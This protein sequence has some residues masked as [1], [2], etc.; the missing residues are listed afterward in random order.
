MTKTPS[1]P[2][3]LQELTDE[4]EAIGRRIGPSGITPEE[5]DALSA[6]LMQQFNRKVAADVDAQLADARRIRRRWVAVAAAVIIA[7]GALALLR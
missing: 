7:A 1:V 4:L 5:A 3:E 2:P 6:E